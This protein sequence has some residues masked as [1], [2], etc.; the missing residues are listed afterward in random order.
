MSLYIPAGYSNILGTVVRT[1][2][3]IKVVKDM[4]QLNLQ[5]NSRFCVLQHQWWY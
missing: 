4:F 3:A 5:H 2:K 1:E